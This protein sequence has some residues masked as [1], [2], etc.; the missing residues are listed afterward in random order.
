[1]IVPMSINSKTQTCR[2]NIGDSQKIWQEMYKVLDSSDVIIEVLDI[3]DPNGTRCMF[4][5]RYVRKNSPHKYIILLLN[6]CDLVPCWVAKKW[7]HILSGQFPVVAFH[8]SLTRPFGKSTLLTILH[9][10]SEI[11]SHK[12]A[13]CV[14][15]FGYPNVGKSSI[16]NTLKNKKVCKSTSIPGETKVWQFVTMMKKMYLIDSPGVICHENQDSETDLIL[17]GAIC[18]EKIKDPI[19]HIPEVLRRIDVHCLEK[20]YQL[21]SCTTAEDFLNKLAHKRGR[22][23]K[24]SGS[25]N[26]TV[27]RIILY[28]WQ[29][30]KLPYFKLPSD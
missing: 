25:D 24:H 12:T 2:F 11:R 13:L 29:R 3:R 16:I 4:L 1:M 28:D 14:G 26:N 20:I 5:E 8:G 7:L 10:I 6:K 21:S 27:A 30:G 18:V 15:F 23:K 9:Q 19:L 17:K 22:F